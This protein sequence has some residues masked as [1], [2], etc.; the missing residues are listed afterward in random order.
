MDEEKANQLAELL[1]GEAWNSG[2]G[3]YI[4]LVR[5]SLGQI[6]GITDESICLYANEQA[7]EDGFAGQSF[8]LV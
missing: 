1:N 5:N 2:G 7:L 6:I 4:V 8:L 3:I